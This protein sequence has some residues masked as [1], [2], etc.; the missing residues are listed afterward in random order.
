MRLCLCIKRPGER[1]CVIGGS[2]TQEGREGGAGQPAGQVRLRLLRCASCVACASFHLRRDS[3]RCTHPIPPH[4]P[5]PRYT[6]IYVGKPSIE[7][8]YISTEITPQ[9][10]RLRDMTYSAPVRSEEGRGGGGR[11]AG[12]GK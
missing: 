4:P 12:R 3:T 8:D 11:E 5:C 10:C 6:A 7:E 9:Q 1:V 2:G